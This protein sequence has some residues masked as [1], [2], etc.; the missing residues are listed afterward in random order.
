MVCS[1]WMDLI[2][3]RVFECRQAL[4]H[5]KELVMKAV[6]MASVLA[7]CFSLMMVRLGVGISTHMTA[8]A[9]RLPAQSSH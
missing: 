4:P 5:E 2:V 3:C 6:M 8:E 7:V 9:M 1:L